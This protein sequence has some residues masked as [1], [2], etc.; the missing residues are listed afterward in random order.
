MEGNSCVAAPTPDAGE[1]GGS[2]EDGATLQDAKTGTDGDAGSEAGPE[3]LPE[4]V[5]LEGGVAMR[6][7]W[8]FAPLDAF[9]DIPLTKQVG[10]FWIARHPITESEYSKCVSAGKCSPPANLTWWCK[11]WT[12]EPKLERANRPAECVTHEQ[13]EEYCEWVGGTLPDMW[14]WYWAV[15]GGVESLYWWG[16]AKPTCEQTP[17]ALELDRASDKDLC[18]EVAHYCASDRFEVGSHPASCNPRGVEDSLMTRAERMVEP[19]LGQVLV[20]GERSETSA[21]MAFADKA[22][23][24]IPAAFRC[25]WE[26]K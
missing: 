5:K 8:D 13:A 26:V 19:A 15:L 1:E 23:A 4:R 10:P 7:A 14:Q 18:C 17:R 24:T 12:G 11:D 6:R 9:A 21:V 2:A 20:S 16:D 3:E 22:S 25:A